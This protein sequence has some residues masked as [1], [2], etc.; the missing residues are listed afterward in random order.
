MRR[1]NDKTTPEMGIELQIMIKKRHRSVNSTVVGWGR[2]RKLCYSMKRRRKRRIRNIAVNHQVLVGVTWYIF[3]IS[4]DFKET[5]KSNGFPWSP[6]R[7]IYVI[8]D[9]VQRLSDQQFLSRDHDYVSFVSPISQ[10]NALLGD[11]KVYMRDCHP[12]S[13]V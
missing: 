11:Q 5:H 7:D 8:L 2:N 9:G 6:C 4:Y 1:M 10:I 13:V 3:Q 12:I